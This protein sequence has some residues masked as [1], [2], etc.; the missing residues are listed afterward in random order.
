MR[1]ETAKSKAL[2]DAH[3]KSLKAK[4]DE[5]STDAESKAA[6]RTYNKALFEKIK[7]IDPSVSEWADRLEAAMMKRLSD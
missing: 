7:K 1:F 6:L 3:I 5:A 4:A 2:E